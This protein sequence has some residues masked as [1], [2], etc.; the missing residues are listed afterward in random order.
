MTTALLLALCLAGPARAEEPV[1]LPLLPI[2]ARLDAGPGAAF[3]S[4]DELKAALAGWAFASVFR[5]GEYSPVTDLVV[6]C[7]R[8]DAGRALIS[9]TDR[10]GAPVEDFRTKITDSRQD[11]DGIAFLVARRLAKGRKTIE[12]A[13]VAHRANLRASAAERGAQALADSD[14]ATA[15]D[16]LYRALE[17]DAEP[18]AL[19]Y[20]LY[21]AHARLGS[22]LRARWYLLLYCEAVDK[23][24]DELTPAQLAP[25]LSIVRAS[26]SDDGF[27]AASMSEWRRLVAEKRGHDAA[28]LLK[29]ILERAPWTVD[30]YFALADVCEEIRWGPLEDGWRKR[31]KLA[32]KAQVRTKNHEILHRLVYPE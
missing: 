11:F 6:T 13:L 29:S 22:A 5:S 4:S 18:A 8:H 23:R 12:A 16:S 30:G 19:Y 1:S 15:A 10:D 28:F 25:L 27:A 20:G 26:R 3:C 31:G 9:V 14:W 2:H 21:V 32:R 24:P 17:S 7:T